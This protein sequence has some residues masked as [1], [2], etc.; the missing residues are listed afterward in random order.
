MQK[1]YK[2]F[3]SSR[4]SSPH[5]VAVYDEQT[6]IYMLF[7]ESKQRKRAFQELYT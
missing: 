2:C 6:E 5:K 7:S 4:P 3:I 1:H